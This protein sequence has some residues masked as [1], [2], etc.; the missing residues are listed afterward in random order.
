MN[1]PN[2]IAVG[3][4]IMACAAACGTPIA[5]TPPPVPTAAVP[6]PTPA[7]PV[8]PGDAGIGAASEAKNGSAEA[9][10]LESVLFDNATTTDAHVTT[11]VD[12]TESARVLKL[13]FPKFLADDKR[14]GNPKTL[15]DARDRGQFVPRVS[16]VATG[17]F[18]E[19]RATQKLYNIFVGECG[20]THADNY[21]TSLLVVVQGGAVIS[22]A[23]G[24]GG[25]SISKVVDV[26]G[27]GKNELVLTS[28]VSAQGTMV[29][30]A[31][32]S[33]FDG[34]RLVAVSD[35]GEVYSGNCAGAFEPKE[36]EVTSVVA[37][38]VVGKP[39]A[40]RITKKKGPCN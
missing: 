38:F 14:C 7:S 33:R 13:L 10:P 35:F 2:G 5:E 6:A 24:A 37:S 32:L 25:D 3:A 16:E 30:T 39:V 27:D 8:P 17:S 26:D 23:E 20:A 21:G 19:A 15:K 18:T 9:K 40:F 31:R 29:S 34:Q 1:K 4:A 12:K 28:G 11:T 22:R 36:E